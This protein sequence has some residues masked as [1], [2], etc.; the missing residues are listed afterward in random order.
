MNYV[1]A[2]ILGIIQG[3]TEWVPVSSS[4]H[5]AIVNRI[6]QMDADLTYYIILHLATLITLLFYFRKDII[7]YLFNK[8]TYLTKNALYVGLAS[9]PIFAVGYFLHAPIS[10]LFI[11]F[12]LIGGALIVNSVVL[13]STRFFNK[14]EPLNIFKALSIGIMQAFALF[15]GISRLGTTVS[16]GI[17]ARVKRE[18]L[19]M[20]T[21][22]LSTAAIVG[23]G[24]Y[25][26]LTTPLNF[27]LPMLVGFL[28]CIPCSYIALTK[29]IKTI[30]A[31]A[32]SKY[33]I[34]CLI[35]GIILL[36]N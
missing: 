21:M 5:L 3:I 22:M 34:Y 2:I 23:A 36:F 24:T 6:M 32:F 10:Q 25:E 9:I 12:K 35:V 11:N 15:P 17:F 27:T 29:L 13:F 1:Q 4:G 30:R 20:F 18:E 16:T 28:V 7:P 8:E 26:L 33:W 19:I 14:E 31:G